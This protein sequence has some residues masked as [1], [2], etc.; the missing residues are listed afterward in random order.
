MRSAVTGGHGQSADRVRFGPSTIASNGLAEPVS[1]ERNKYEVYAVIT[2]VNAG[3]PG[4]K[5]ALSLAKYTSQ[6]SFLESRVP[7]HRDAGTESAVVGL[8]GIFWMAAYSTDR[9]KAKDRVI[10]LPLQCEVH[11]VLQVLLGGEDRS[12]GVHHK[13]LH[14]VDFVRRQLR[15]PLQSVIKRQSR[16]DF[17]GIVVVQA[18]A[19]DNRSVGEGLRAGQVK[20]ISASDKQL[21][22]RPEEAQCSSVFGIPRAV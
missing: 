2:V 17:P 9:L 10:D 13:I 14:A 3:V 22:C 18:V 1:Q 21:R 7:C 15:A 12:A 6:D 5:N 20:V 4:T 19:I 16:A 8:E 11:R